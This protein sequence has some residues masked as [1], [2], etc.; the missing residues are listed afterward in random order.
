MFALP[1]G[2]KVAGAALGGI[3][4]VYDLATVTAELPDRAMKLLGDAEILV[5]R[6]GILIGRME[7]TATDAAQALERVNATSAE[8]AEAIGRITATNSEAASAI[9]RIVATNDD[10]QRLVGTADALL[11]RTE[12]IVAK[13][14]PLAEKFVDNLSPEE[15]D[16]AIKLVDQLPQLTEHL[17]SDILPILATLDRVGPDLNELLKVTYDVRRAILGIPGFGFFKKRGEER[18]EETEAEEQEQ[19]E[20]WEEAHRREDAHRQETGQAAEQTTGQ[21]HDKQGAAP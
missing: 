7:R 11:R 21:A 19:R 2:A 4:K 12:P 3:G 14:A 17:Q 10:A 9:T 6:V 16:A 8:A 18:L 13:A 15:I 5:T 20:E 1:S